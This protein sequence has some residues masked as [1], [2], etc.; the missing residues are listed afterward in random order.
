MDPTPFFSDF[1]D[2]K[3]NLHIFFSYNLLAVI[4]SSFLKILF[5]AKI[6]CYNFTYFAS[7]I[8]VRSTPL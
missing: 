2:A 5:F 1:K 6:L 4:L 7:I 3:K 8:S